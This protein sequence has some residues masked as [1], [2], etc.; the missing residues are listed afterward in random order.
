MN[1]TGNFTALGEL[2]AQRDYSEF[3]EALEAAF[4][5]LP[6]Q[7]HQPLRTIAGNGLVQYVTDDGKLVPAITARFIRLLAMGFATLTDQACEVL[8]QQISNIA[9]PRS[10]EEKPLTDSDA[11]TEPSSR[12][13]KPIVRLSD[14]ATVIRLRRV[15]QVT[16]YR[17][18]TQSVSDALGLRQSV[19]RSVQERFFLR[20][21]AL[22]FPGLT[23]LPNYP[24]DQ[25]AD[26]SKLRS[27]LDDE[28]IRFGKACRLDAL[29]VIPDEGDPVAA[30]ELDSRYHDDSSAKRRDQLKDRLL[31]LLGVP[32]FRLRAEEGN[33]MDTDEWYALLT[34]EVLS[35]VTCGDRIR[36]RRLHSALVPVAS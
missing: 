7:A 23:A 36:S 20:A 22:R 13:R 1:T 34:D 24:L 4:G 31:Q 10:R 25:I 35:E 6:E 33:A 27:I 28:T 30:F 14:A 16:D 18:G 9:T 17:W 12:P 21:L 19:F 29:L 3:L 2:L 8:A 32:L 11:I 26:F 15:V 5:N